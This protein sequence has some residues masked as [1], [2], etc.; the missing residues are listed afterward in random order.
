MITSAKDVRVHSHTVGAGFKKLEILELAEVV[1]RCKDII[2]RAILLDME[3][4]IAQEQT[5][6]L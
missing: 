3:N 4:S 1:S 2:I 5:T 6:G